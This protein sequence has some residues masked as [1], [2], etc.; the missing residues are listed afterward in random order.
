M[1]LVALPSGGVLHQY[2]SRPTK[3]SIDGCTT[4]GGDALT[5]GELVVRGTAV[6]LGEGEIPLA[7][8]PDG[9]AV[10]IAKGLGG[11]VVVRRLDGAGAD[12]PLANPAG[13]G[14]FVEG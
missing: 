4:A 13:V 14:F 3:F 7:I 5:P 2:A 1:L 8:S 12:V 11:S 10:L 6:L 9:T